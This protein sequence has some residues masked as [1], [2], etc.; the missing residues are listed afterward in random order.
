MVTISRRF[1][2]LLT[3]L[4]LILA[5]LTT[6]APAEAGVL[7]IAGT[8]TGATITDTG[9]TPFHGGRGGTPQQ[10]RCGPDSALTGLVLISDGSTYVNRGYGAGLEVYCTQVDSTGSISGAPV[11]A[12]IVTSTDAVS[13]SGKSSTSCTTGDVVTGDLGR[14]GSLIDA[15]GV[16][17]STLSGGVLSA[18]PYR[19]TAPPGLDTGG[20]AFGPDACP[21][22]SFAT[23]VDAQ[24]GEDLDGFSLRCGQLTTAF[25]VA[26]LSVTTGLCSTDSCT[27]AS[28]GPGARDVPVSAI[29]SYALS[30]AA[31]DAV[32]SAPLR[33][34]PLRSVPLRSVPL[35]SV[36]L[37]SVPLRSVPLASVLLS[38][39]PL[40]GTTWQLILAGTSLASSPLET[41]TLTA[42]LAALDAAGRPGPT[43]DQVDLTGTPLSDLSV[44]SIFLGSSGIGS[45]P[46]PPPT[47]ATT[48]GSAYGNWCAWLSSLGYSCSALGLTSSSPV[49]A[50]DL[51]G[52]PLRSVPLRSVPLRSVPVAAPL[53]SVPLRSVSVG[54]SP[55]GAVP[56]RR[57]TL[58]TGGTNNALGAIGLTTLSPTSA[59]GNIVLT[60]AT[61]PTGLLTGCVAGDTVCPTLGAALGSGH[62][63]ATATLGLITALLG[64]QTLGDLGSALG[65]AT[66]G[67]LADAIDP[68]YNLTLGDALLALVPS[69][70]VPWEQVALDPLQLSQYDSQ[71]APLITYA[72]SMGLQGLSDTAGGDAVLTLPPGFRYTGQ[73]DLGSGESATVVGQDIHIHLANRAVPATQV[74]HLLVN[75]GLVL[76]SFAVPALSLHLTSV[77]HGSADA[78]TSET[79]GGVNVV[80]TAAA[81]NSPSTGAIIAP[82]HLVVGHI[83]APGDV[84]YYRLPVPPAGTHIH[85]LLS[86][87]A[88][89]DDLVVYGAPADPAAP[90]AAPLRSVPLRSVPLLDDGIGTA[91]TGV[92]PTAQL[93]NDVPLRTDLA[94]LGQSAH[95]GTADEEVGALSAGGP[96]YLTV[97]V[98]GYNGAWS[99][100]PYL[101]RVVE[102]S[103]VTTTCPL[104]GLGPQSV[105]GSLPVGTSATRALL[106]VNTQQLNAEYGA[107]AASALLTKLGTFASRADVAGLVVPVDADPS[108]VGAY[109]AWNSDPCSANTANNVVNSVNAIVRSYQ[110]GS[111][112]G[113]TSVTLVGSDSQLP[114]Y[115]TP[116]LTLSS[117]ESG[118]AE[119][120]AP[121][122]GGDNPLSAAQRHGDLLTD[123]AYGSLA[124]VSWLDRRLFLP[125]LAVGR[126]VETPLEIGSQLDQFVAAGGALTPSS[127]LTTGYDFLADGAHAVDTALTHDVGTG[128][129]STL[130]DEPGST[131][132]WTHT[133]L[134]AALFPTGSTS[135]FLTGLNAHFDHNRAL[136]SAGNI[137]GSQSDLFTVGDITANPGRLVGRLLF[138]MGCHA[139]LNVPDRY[140]GGA[141]VPVAQDWAQTFANQ[142]AIWVANT[143]FGLG[144]TASVALSEELMKQFAVRLD[145][146]MSAGQALQY[147][148][149]AYFGELGAYGVYDE[150]ALEEAVYYG[151]PMWRVGGPKYDPSTST[152]VPAPLVAP[153]AQVDPVA[154]HATTAAVTDGGLSAT[155]V[156]VAPTFTSTTIARGRFWAVGG[157]TQVTHY[158]P[159]QP[160]TSV[161]V[162][163]P[164]GQTA[165]G[166]LLTGL[167][168]QDTTGVDPVFAR[169]TIDQ[170]ANEPEASLGN[171]TFPAQFSALTSFATPVG[172]ATRLVLLPGQFIANSVGTAGTQRLFT[173][174]AAR[175]LY[176]ASSSYAPPVLT[177]AAANRGPGNVTFTVDATAQGGAD[178]ARVLVLFHQ[179]G[180]ST[181]TRLELSRTTG[182]TFSA[183]TPVGTGSVE[184][185]AEAQDSFGNTATTDN[186]GDLFGAASS[187]SSST[188]G[189]AGQAG[190]FTSPVG[191]DASG[192]AAHYTVVVDGVALGPVPALLMTDGSHVVRVDGSDGTS[193]DLGTIKIDTLAPT[194]AF[195]TPANGTFLVGSSGSFTAVCS[196]GPIG[197]GVAS[198]CPATGTVNTSTPRPGTA[199]FTLTDVAGNSSTAGLSYQV[200]WAFAGFFSPVS[201]PTTLN[202]VHA[203]S[204]VPVKFSLQN[205]TGYVGAL[206]N[207]STIDWQT[208]SCPSGV[209]TT[210]VVATDATLS[211]LKYDATANQYIYT[212]KTPKALAASCQR[213]TVVLADSTSHTA[214][215][216]FS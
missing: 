119:T 57:L 135:P 150:K 168:S 123:D 83:S 170:S 110:A 134:D 33:S 55:L 126:L 162:S 5:M 8:P 2:V 210:T 20:N 183:T 171:A 178:I 89:D 80:D 84:R 81:N 37:R 151:L 186:K 116:D 172:T 158:R 122:A 40:T 194:A 181:W 43:L 63:N 19:V 96:G 124:P 105:T 69:S 145:G 101:L 195:A 214:L 159:I 49:L 68:L 56:L 114:M 82:D 42:A 107:T 100:A 201:N 128:A 46:I 17:C 199:A 30:A 144:D 38:Q 155:D 184:W 193:H 112:P 161:G 138:S 185:L 35:R 175:V 86:H 137:S 50:A 182:S 187:F 115:R 142:K 208:I 163:P 132:G 133:Q 167:V 73:N 206:G 174:M 205:A 90:A 141:T 146:S 165:H 59:L 16:L 149:Q 131:S 75:P 23:G 103:P 99:N 31:T 12:G 77:S 79:D 117:N 87:L 166:A 24:S 10:V 78:S 39:I 130:I 188:T 173:S 70:T 36:P 136:P 85:V 93:L 108:T 215:F 91:V 121:P 64:D 160:R 111:A 32:V 67:D 18:S 26:S 125:D 169:P 200:Q 140:V 44:A 192:P 97:Q 41:V 71:N 164:A 11:R 212:W 209:A 27:G 191:V 95:H 6:S 148:K 113:L 207:V 179:P 104:L 147:A 76:G 3:V 139:G 7:P 202:R 180:V 15:V 47:G 120:D 61:A 48:D 94:L 53:R 25:K 58:T 211:S 176:S 198:G 197:S 34:V 60:A 51:A 28:Y 106:M 189:T 154:A 196:D 4:L 153:A 65:S 204:T 152:S 143:G 62:V 66:L 13:A 157:E 29:P 118:Y 45:L 109:N 213:L 156:T 21:A 52:V 22:G 92:A 54:T 102:D 9:N 129:H 1:T 74:V 203:G 190:W 177:N 88:S 216:Q 72:V 98:S 14:A 127:A